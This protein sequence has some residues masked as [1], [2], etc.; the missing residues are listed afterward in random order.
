MTRCAGVIM[1]TCLNLAKVAACVCLLMFSACGIDE[2]YTS[3]GEKASPGDPLYQGGQSG[4]DII[5]VCTCNCQGGGGDEGLVGQSWVMDTFALGNPLNTFK[6]PVND[7]I[8][9]EIGKGTIN[10]LMSVT[11]DQTD[12]V[13]AADDASDATDPLDATETVESAG[14][15]VLT[16]DFGV[17]TKDGATYSFTGTPTTVMANL[18]STGAFEFN[19]GVERF[20]LTVPMEGADPITIPILKVVLAGTISTDGG[21]IANGTL[22]GIVSVEDAQKTNVMIGT[23]YDI[24]TLSE[25]VQPD[26]DMDGDGTMDGWVFEGTFTSKTCTIE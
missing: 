8:R 15:R 25:G 14:G 23:L 16:I 6:A 4:Q 17:G 24:L 3:L 13:T 22:R 21:K 1:R 5:V 20:V 2:Y 9:T 7:F 18:E 12:A 19:E 11:D 26:A 10:I